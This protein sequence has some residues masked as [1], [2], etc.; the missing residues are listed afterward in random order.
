MEFLREKYV[1][2][3]QI[4]KG[5]NGVRKTIEYLKKNYSESF[6]DRSKGK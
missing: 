3:N 4:K 6:N 2:K 5:I 1:C